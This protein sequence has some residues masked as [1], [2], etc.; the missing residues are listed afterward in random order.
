[1]LDPAPK[2]EIT[3]P[4]LLQANVRSSVFVDRHAGVLE[5][6]DACGGLAV[7]ASQCNKATVL[8]QNVTMEIRKKS[9]GL[10]GRTVATPGLA[11]ELIE[12]L[13]SANIAGDFN[14][15]SRPFSFSK[16][17][18]CSTLESREHMVITV[19]QLQPMIEKRGGRDGLGHNFRASAI[20]PILPLQLY[21]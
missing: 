15:N 1:M 3:G 12:V 4:K 6:E 20:L 2:N 10:R 16:G 8:L 18:T 21:T 9:K 13:Q 17:G 19:F 14:L 11:Q 7:L 5:K